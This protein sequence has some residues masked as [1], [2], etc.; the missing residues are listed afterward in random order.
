MLQAMSS[1]SGLLTARSLATTAA[2]TWETQLRATWRPPHDRKPRGQLKCGLTRIGEPG[3]PSSRIPCEV[4]LISETPRHGQEQSRIYCA[5][6]A[7]LALGLLAAG[8]QTKRG[9][10]QMHVKRF[11]AEY[12]SI[13]IWGLAEALHPCCL[14]NVSQAPGSSLG[15]NLDALDGQSLIISAVKA[16]RGCLSGEACWVPFLGGPFERVLCDNGYP[17]KGP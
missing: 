13:D 11:L 16:R 1:G 14:M 6:R 3:P 5:D 9:C 12:P 15:L 4:S 17:Q 10:T 2:G 7:R 8:K